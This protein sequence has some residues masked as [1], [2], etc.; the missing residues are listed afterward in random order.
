MG[1]FSVGIVGYGA[2]SHVQCF[3]DFARALAQALRDLGHEV[4]PTHDAKPGRLIMFGANNMSDPE[5]KLPADAI[6]FNTEQLL[7]NEGPAFHFQNYKGFANHVVWDYS[8]ANIHQLHK[9]GIAKTVLC[10]VAYHPSMASID[11]AEEDIDVLFYGSVNPRRREILDALDNAGIKVERLFNVYGKERDAFIA[12]SKIV[13]NLHFYER[14][15]F[16]IFRVSHLLA[17]KRCV[18]TEDGGFDAP[19]EVFAEACAF[20]ET[21]EHIVESCKSLL[22]DGVTRAAVAARGFAQF[23]ETSLVTN[24]RRAL[25]AS[26]Q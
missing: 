3:E 24:V 7:I 22:A 10:P 4:V 11:P 25:E 9:L 19:L 2:N 20:Y 15:V 5:G 18:V 23:T 16:E 14:A 8:T 21:R 13:L 12:R 6:V 1:R 17:N 26:G